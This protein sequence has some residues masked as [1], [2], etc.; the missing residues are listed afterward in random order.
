MKQKVK[1]MLQKAAKSKK[2]HH[3]EK[4]FSNLFPV[5]MEDGGQRL[6]INLMEFNTFIPCKRFKIEGLHL[7][8]KNYEQGDY[9]W[10]VDLKDA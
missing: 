5:S 2:M 9:M 1:K 3:K 6:V 4:F 8:R 7:L 10:I